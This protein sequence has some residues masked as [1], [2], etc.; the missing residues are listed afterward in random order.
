[1]SHSRI[2]H[3][4]VNHNMTTLL[5]AA[6]EEAD[7]PAHRIPPVTSLDLER[8]AWYS[9]ICRI[10]GVDEAGRGCLAG[11]VVAAA[12]IFEPEHKIEGVTDSK[13]MSQK[14]REHAETKIREQALS[15]G[16]GICSPQEIDQ[17][18]ILWASME[19]MRRAVI[20]LD[21]EPELLF[22]DGNRCFKN[23]RWP[24]KTLVKGDSRSHSI[25]AASIIAK[26]HRDR[27]MIQLN[28]ESP[29]FNWASNKG[30]PTKDHYR[31]LQENGPTP[32]HRRSFRLQ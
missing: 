23:S 25:A 16:I 20:G 13:K 21:L 32:H 10:A 24:F 1:M 7:T 31:A 12:V 19:A 11:P 18:N 14:A 29:A 8:I 28:A 5:S 30:Y 27:L 9:G 4:I 17:L 26:T 22:I 2:N 15:I 6:L 3:S